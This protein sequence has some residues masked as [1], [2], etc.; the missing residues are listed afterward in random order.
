MP[1]RTT[2]RRLRVSALQPL[3]SA[4]ARR[5]RSARE[6]TAAMRLPCSVCTVAL[7]EHFNARNRWTS[8]KKDGAR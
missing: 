1:R 2:A 5:N 4:I 3:L 7:S 6:L 8:C